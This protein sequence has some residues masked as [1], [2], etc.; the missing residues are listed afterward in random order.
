MTG[1]EDPIVVFGT[2]GLSD[3]KNV[4]PSPPPQEE[5]TNTTQIVNS[6]SGSV[7]N[8]SCDC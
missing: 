7:P 3:N 2:R 6:F 8:S 5:I 1:T 4:F